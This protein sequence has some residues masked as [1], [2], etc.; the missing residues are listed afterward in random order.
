[1]QRKFGKSVA[2]ANI[3]QLREMI[4]YK[5]SFCDRRFVEIN[6]KFSTMTCSACGSRTGPSGIAGLR[7]RHWVCGCG[8]EHDRDVNA[9][10]NTLN[11][12]AGLAVELAA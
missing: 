2:N 5:S 3:Y 9:A 7:V 1:M 4:A 12:A 8:A 6:G 11:A 10:I